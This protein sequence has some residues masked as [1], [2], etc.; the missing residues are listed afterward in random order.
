MSISF[1]H[2]RSFGSLALVLGS[3]VACGGGGDGS[4]DKSDVGGTAQG[5]SSSGGAPGSGAKSSG[6]TPAGGLSMAG[7]GTS[8]DASGGT[9]GTPGSCAGSCSNAPAGSCS[10][11]RVRV[12]SVDIGEKLNYSTDEVNVVPLAIAAKPGG[13][14]RIAWMTGYAH[15]G[16]STASKVHIADLDCDDKLVGTPFTFEAYDFQDLAADADGGVV[17]VTRD[18]QGSGDQHCGD[19]QNLC[20]LP[21]DRPGCY[22]TYLVRHD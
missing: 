18:A 21:N 13:G 8:G 2:A 1:S 4:D 3:L 17:M 7:V 9:P 14:S 6:G 11:P 10:A 22:D 16:S 20:F 12:T 15:Y 19:V 5:A